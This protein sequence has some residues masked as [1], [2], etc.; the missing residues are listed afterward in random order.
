MGNQNIRYYYNRLNI[1]ERLIVLNVAVFILSGLLKILFGL[2]GD[3]IIRWFEL[4]KD[5]FHFLAQ[6]W[7]IVT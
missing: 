3:S 4:P 5:F 2:S 6:P 1:A 7:S